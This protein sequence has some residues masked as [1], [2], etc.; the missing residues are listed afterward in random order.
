V[1]DGQTSPHRPRL[2]VSRSTCPPLFPPPPQREQLCTRSCSNKH[3]GG[4][5]RPA[6]RGGP[7]T[8]PGGW[9]AQWG[10]GD[11]HGRAAGAQDAP[12]RGRA[13]PFG[14][15]VTDRRGPRPLPAGGAWGSPDHPR[16]GWAVG[17]APRSVRG[18][19]G[20]ARTRRFAGA[21]RLLGCVSRTEGGPAPSQPAVRRGPQTPP[22]GGWALGGAPRS[23]RGRGGCA[24]TRRFGRVQGSGTPRFGG[25]AIECC[26]LVLNSVTATPQWIRQPEAAW[27]CVWC[28]C[29]SMYSDLL[30]SLSL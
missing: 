9:G 4:P 17:G 19:G 14:W 12:I 29:V 26:L 18:R 8:T 15:C 21:S 28:L 2:V 10:P 5:S 25:G 30:G 13:P 11:V 6:V 16:G 3:T 7:R 1:R 23:V 27:L 22:R 24:R 20:R